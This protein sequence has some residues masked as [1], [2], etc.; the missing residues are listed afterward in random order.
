M[1][2]AFV[3][4]PQVAVATRQSGKEKAEGE[5]KKQKNEVDHDVQAEARMQ[6]TAEEFVFYKAV[7]RRFPR[8]SGSGASSTLS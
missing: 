1:K 6:L 3:G 4:R 5:N 8:R 7:S 2:M